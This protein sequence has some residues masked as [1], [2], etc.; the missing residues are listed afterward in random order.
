M[1]TGGGKGEALSGD[2]RRPQ[3]QSDEGERPAL[4]DPAN[5]WPSGR[6][7]IWAPPATL[8]G[9]S[10]ARGDRRGRVE[11][12]SSFGVRLLRRHG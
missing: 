4:W 9:V 6:G 12:L 5:A 3:S 1:R 7:L 2:T 8:V 11:G 10:A